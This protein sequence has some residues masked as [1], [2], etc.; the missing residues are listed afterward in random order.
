VLTDEVALPILDEAAAL[1]STVEF[2]DPESVV[3]RYHHK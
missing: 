2:D 3:V 1:E